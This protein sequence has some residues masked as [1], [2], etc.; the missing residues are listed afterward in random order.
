MTVAGRRHITSGGPY[1]EAVGYSR[2]VVDGDRCWVS[3][4]TDAGPGGASR[5]P[6]DARAQSVAAFEIV[7]GALAEAGFRLADVVRTRIYLVDADDIPAVT[8]VHGDL[9]RDIRPAATLVIVAGLMEPSL[10]VEVEVDAV[11][12]P[13]S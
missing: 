8:A 9:F 1:E 3:G 2:A 6:G 11:R 12:S 10:V 13:G 7:Q 4:T 5:H